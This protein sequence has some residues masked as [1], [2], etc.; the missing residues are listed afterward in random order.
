LNLNVD[1]YY[2]SVYFFLIAN[3]LVIR[4]LKQK[5]NYLVIRSVVL[6]T[7]AIDNSDFTVSY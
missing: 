6:T 2:V 4:A 1:Y 7:N 3:I 5:Y